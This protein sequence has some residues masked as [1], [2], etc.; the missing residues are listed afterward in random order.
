MAGAALTPPPHR[1]RAPLAE[2]MRAQA[3]RAVQ[4]PEPTPE[5]GAPAVRLACV[6]AAGGYALNQWLN[7]LEGRPRHAL[8][9]AVVVRGPLGVAPP[10]AGRARRSPAPPARPARPP[11][12]APLAA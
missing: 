6:L 2:A 10:A 1:Q 5:V 11:P 4:A 8:A 9:L 3:V 12:A 7:L